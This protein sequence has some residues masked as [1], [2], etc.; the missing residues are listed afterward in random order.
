M[1]LKVFNPGDILAAADVMEY[2]ENTRLAIKP[3][4]TNKVSNATLSNDPDLT[5]TADANKSYWMEAL[6]IFQSATAANL[7]TKFTVP[8]SSNFYGAALGAGVGA[9]TSAMNGL[10]IANPVTTV[11]HWAGFAAFEVAVRYTGI[12]ATAGTG[13]PVT[14]QWAQDTS[15]ATTTAVRQGSSLFLRRVA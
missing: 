2:L 6:I 15:Q 1:A 5:V 3:G 10:D 13:G 8:A 12:L 4:D 11:L 14:L 9:S 7:Q